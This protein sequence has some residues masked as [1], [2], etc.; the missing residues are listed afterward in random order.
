MMNLQLFFHV[1]YLCYT[2][3]VIGGKKVGIAIYVTFCVKIYENLILSHEVGNEL[4][5]NASQRYLGL[6]GCMQYSLSN[7]IARGGSRLSHWSHMRQSTFSCTI[8]FLV[9][10][11]VLLICT[12]SNQL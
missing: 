10:W 7:I 4:T 1:Y 6:L 9:T 5:E 12:T 11:K 8:I 2:H 3:D